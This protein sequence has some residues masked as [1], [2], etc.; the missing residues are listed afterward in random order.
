MT[1]TKISLST[2]QKRLVEED[3]IRRAKAIQMKLSP[4]R[5]S[6]E[7]GKPSDPSKTMTKITQISMP[8]R[9][10][11]KPSDTG[12]DIPT[13]DLAGKIVDRA[14]HMNF[15]KDSDRGEPK[16]ASVK[17][18]RKPNQTTN[19]KQVGNTIKRTEDD[20][21][22]KTMIPNG[23]DA[24][25]IA[26]RMSRGMKSG[27]DTT[28]TVKAPKPKQLDATTVG[29]LKPAKA[30]FDRGEKKVDQVNFRN[31]FVSEP[32]DAGSRKNSAKKDTGGA[33]NVVESGIEVRLGGK[34]KAIFDLV[35]HQ[36]LNRMVES[37]AQHG[38][39]LDIVRT[40]KASW[41]N[42]KEFLRTLWESIDAGFNRVPKQKEALRS[43][44]RNQ[45][46]RLAQGSF[47]SLYESRDEFIKTVDQAFRQVEQNA[48][49]KYTESLELMTCMARFEVDGDVADAEVITEANSHQM[50]LR[51][52]RN[53][54]MEQYGM[55][56]KLRHIFVDGTKYLPHQIKGWN[57]KKS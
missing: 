54:M 27:S 17:S 53:K 28:P 48:L 47:N 2:A 24:Y 34:V 36:V 16:A 41:K 23:Q 13:A 57:G 42:D 3:E 8:D 29:K 55:G 33:H 40:G 30:T 39:R 52:V 31:G 22:H 35:N 20:N 4:N 19:L 18:G 37:F 43:S 45:F 46:F 26:H 1:R 5:G 21:P 11:P 10:M 51:Q 32:S 7:V 15:G 44:A 12:L 50:A 49:R 38:Y 56:M 9:T 6:R 14:P 25:E